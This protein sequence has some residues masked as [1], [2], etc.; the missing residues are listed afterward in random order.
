MRNAILVG[1]AAFCLLACGG[2][3]SKE[4]HGT[5]DPRPP[6]VEIMVDKV[7]KDLVG[8]EV[9]AQG[10]SWTFEHSDR[11][12]FLIEESIYTEDEASVLLD[13][14][15]SRERSHQILEGQMRLYYKWENGQ[16][17]LEDIENVSAAVESL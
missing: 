12:T 6:Q 2:H 4:L 8:Q 1:L 10:K 5:P 11:K 13:V 3:G 16:W 15:I 7:N 9:K 17:H 14:V